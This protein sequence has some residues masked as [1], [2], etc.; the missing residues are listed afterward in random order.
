M[1]D[2]FEIL[3]ALG[4]VEPP[5][6]ANL[7]AALPLTVEIDGK[8]FSRMAF[9]VGGVVG[10]N[11]IWVLCYAHVSTG[12]LAVIG[13]GICPRAAAAS[14]WVNLKDNW[15]ELFEQTESGVEEERPCTT[16]P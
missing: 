10:A 8:V 2:I 11:E 12:A 14:L 4:W 13:L 16:S 3:T 9:P 6:L 7:L 5:T 15:P 1:T